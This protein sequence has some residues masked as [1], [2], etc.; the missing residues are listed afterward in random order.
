MSSIEFYRSERMAM[1]SVEPV[2]KFNLRLAVAMVLREGV[3][4]LPLKTHSLSQVNLA[5]V[6]PGPELIRS[7]N[8]LFSW[9]CGAADIG[10]RGLL[11]WLTQSTPARGP[12]H[13]QPLG[14][15]P[16]T[17]PA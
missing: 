14:R 5:F 9:P 16:K 12:S 10:D 3:I 1:A 8:V 11:L 2:Q 17:L 4:G 7:A 15:E 6:R 13:W